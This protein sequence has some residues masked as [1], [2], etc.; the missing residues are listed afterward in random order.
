[1]PLVAKMTPKNGARAIIDIGL[2]EAARQ[3]REV[4]KELF[5]EAYSKAIEDA[6]NMGAEILFLVFVRVL[7]LFVL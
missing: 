6:R 4:P 2:A 3:A 7:L 5:P 1:V